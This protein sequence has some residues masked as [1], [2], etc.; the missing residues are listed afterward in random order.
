MTFT[1]KIPQYTSFVSADNDGV[2]DNG[3]ITWTKEVE[4]GQ[5]VT[6]SF[7][8][9]VNDDVNGNP[10]DNQGHVKDGVNEYDTNTT[11]NPTPKVPDQPKK[12]ENPKPHNPGKPGLQKPK[13]SDSGNLPLM[14]FLLIS[15]SGVLAGALVKKRK[16]QA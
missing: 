4:N 2:N 14:M 6:V 7:K 13:T 12:P 3:T 11:H 10:V 15:S 8:V 9:K 5:T 1:D 16:K